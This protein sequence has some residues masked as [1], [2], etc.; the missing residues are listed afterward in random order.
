[1]YELIRLHWQDIIEI[2]FF[3]YIFYATALWLKKDR[4]H[5]LLPYF[6]GFILL[7]SSS[8]LLNLSS[9]S[10]MLCYCWPIGIMLFILMHQNGLQRNFVALK[11]NISLQHSSSPW[12]ETLVASHLLTLSNNKPVYCIIEHTDSLDA[13]MQTPITIQAPLNKELLELIATS[14][15]FNPHTMIWVT[16]NGI[17]HGINSRWRLTTPTHNSTQNTSH[18]TNDYTSNTNNSSPTSNKHSSLILHEWLNATLQH[19]P[20]TDCCAFYGDPASRTFILIIKD[21]TIT[22]LSAHQLLQILSSEYVSSTKTTS[23]FTKKES[24]H[25]NVNHHKKPSHE[26]R[27]P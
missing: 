14:T 2:L 8:Y 9:I 27:A 17:V 22:H 5:N 15:L 23:L 21:K 6:Y 4:S 10:F 13:F 1:M 7:Y 24:L 3:S 26:Q 11:N 20:H 18:S 25:V 16:T 12:L 19:T